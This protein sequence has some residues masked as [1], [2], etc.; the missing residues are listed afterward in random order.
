MN[1]GRFPKTELVPHGYATSA[2]GITIYRG[3]AYGSEYEGDAF[4]GEPANNVVVR[5]KIH[6][7]GVGI[8][9]ER[10]PADGKQ[11]ASSSLRRITGFV[12]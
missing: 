10:P 1:A 4:I 9:A 12:P 5:L 7:N 8:S 11:V 3:G 6:A 2:A